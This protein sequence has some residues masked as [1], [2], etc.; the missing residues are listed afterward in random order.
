MKTKDMEHL[1]SNNP[2]PGRG[3]MMGMSPSGESAVVAYFIMG[4]SK[5]S[6]N[7]VFVQDGDGVRI[8]AHDL[9]KV[10]DPSLIFYRPILETAHSLVLTNGDQTDTIYE[11]LTRGGS[12]ISALNTRK[13]EPDGP[14][15]TPRISGVLDKATGEFML[16]ILRASDDEGERCDRL[17]FNYAARKGFG[18]FIHT[19]LGDENPLP[20]FT[21]EPREVPV[22]EDIEAF[23]KSLWAHLNPD[24]RVALYVRK[25]YL[26]DKTSQVYVYNRH[27]GG[28][29]H[30]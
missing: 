16:S 6:R 20:S 10:E 15:F 8:L 27:E 1:L 2:Y 26:K 18:R 11:H 21:G 13:H 23:A 19:Y 14:H 5:N 29:K 22:L 9:S 12:A 7:R 3:V 4:R 30:A 28:E 24:Y 17:Y 25:Y